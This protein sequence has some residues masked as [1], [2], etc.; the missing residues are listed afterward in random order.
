MKAAESALS[1]ALRKC[2]RGFL[3]AAFFSLVI[4]VL[5]LTAPLY[6]LQVFDRVLTSRN[7]DTLIMLTLGAGFA[8]LALAVL[9]VVRNAIMVRVGAWIDQSLSDDVLAISVRQGL[10]RGATKNVQGLRDLAAV[11][12]FLSG[13]QIFPI[14]DA[15]WTPMFLGVLFLLHEEL[16]WL[17]TSGAV[18][19]F[20]LAMVNEIATRRLFD[21]S[22]QGSIAAT[23]QAD[24]AV[25]NSDAIQAMG[26]LPGIVRRWRDSNRK[27]VALNAKANSRSGMIRAVVRFIRLFLQ[28]AI[29]GYGAWLVLRVELTPGGMIAGSI[30]LARA[31]APVDQSIAS[32][33]SAV[34]ARDAYRRLKSALLEYYDPSEAMPLPRP[35]GV[36]SVEDVSFIPVGAT[37]PIVKKVSF[38]LEP[39]TGLG[40]V[41]ATAAGKS[42]LVRLLV[43]TH[44]PTAGHIRLDGMDMTQWEPSDRGRHVGYIPQDVELFN[45]TVRDNIARMGEA[46]PDKVIEAAQIANV[47][48]MIMRLPSGYDT[49]LGE[50]GALLSGG[51]RQRI[52]LARAVFGNPALLVLDEP[53]ASL[54]Q[55]GEAALLNTVVTLK[56]SGVTVVIVAHRPNLMRVV[57]K[58]LVL[59]DGELKMLDDRDRIL[60]ALAN[61]QHSESVEQPK[62]TT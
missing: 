8:F 50:R 33:R 23:M 59:R 40:I 27:V 43:G 47:H 48:D 3:T 38:T 12:N 28:V 44:T 20:V 9:E 52:A 16:G 61:A 11:R 26:M 37:Q 60:K 39:G 46:D 49:V 2:H 32:W 53:G 6:M 31:L 41:G 10:G 45:A 13:A 17:S 57:D 30:L 19:L 18:L 54:D 42:T 21:A 1:R 55:E 14:M 25:R 36:L 34:Q 58:I 15:P 7:Q 56:Q 62:E 5:M 24:S 35:L 29:L 51:Q 22:G 4:N